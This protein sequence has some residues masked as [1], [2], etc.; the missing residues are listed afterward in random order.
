MSVNEIIDF[1]FENYYKQNGFSKESS[2]YSTKRLKKKDLL[3]LTNK[4][5]EKVP[6]PGSA[7]EHYKS[8]LRKKNRKSV[9][10]QK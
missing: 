8:F 1:I 9:K 6:D 10:H 3:L 4:L 7:K 2:Y 5:I